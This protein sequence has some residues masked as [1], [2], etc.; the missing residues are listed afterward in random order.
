MSSHD[1]TSDQN[2]RTLVRGVL[3]G[4]TLPAYAE[5]DYPT[6]SEL[7]ELKAAAFAD[8]AKRLH[9]VHTKQ[10]TFMSALYVANVD[11]D[12]PEA[13]VDNLRKAASVHD[14][15]Q[16]VE[17]LLLQLQQNKKAS[18]QN[19]TDIYALRDGDKAFYPLGTQFDLEKSAASIASDIRFQLLPVRHVRSA[20]E[21][22]VKRARD[23]RYPLDDLPPDILR[24]GIRIQPS[25]ETLYKQAEWRERLTQEPLYKQ[26]V[27]VYAKTLDE[28]TLCECAEA[29]HQLDDMHQV[30]AGNLT[31]PVLT[32]WCSGVTE[33][34]VK[35]ASRHTLWFGSE[36]VP[37]GVLTTVPLDT[38]KSWFGAET[39][40]KM[41]AIH[42]AAQSHGFEASDLLDALSSDER[43][44]LAG[45]LRRFHTTKA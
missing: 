44:V 3:A 42:K 22:L 27:D 31:P 6:A 21:A 30:K 8:P 10:A 16:D 41:A 32:C 43:A 11:A 40:E 26:A 36:A 17:P 5:G 24:Y 33:E 39:Q 35:E 29:W 34:E 4:A 1:F 14:I 37:S 15:T 18:T 19:T 20:C 2:P 25:L 13:V 9:P 38:L 12:V 23:M 28:N 45:H 7:H